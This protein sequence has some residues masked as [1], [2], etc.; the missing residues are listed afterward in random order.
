[1]PHSLPVLD[2]AMLLVSL[3]A[4]ANL[5]IVT[6]FDDRRLKLLLPFG[7][8]FIASFIYFA[9]PGASPLSG[10][11]IVDALI[12]GLVSLMLATIIRP[13]IW[14]LVRNRTDEG[15]GSY[16]KRLDSR[17]WPN[18][19]RQAPPLVLDLARRWFVTI[20]AATG[21]ILGAVAANRFFWDALHKAFSLNRIAI[22]V[23]ATFLSL[24]LLGPIE[25]FVFD[26]ATESPEST[27]AVLRL[28]RG[29]VS[30]RSYGRILLVFLAIF[31]LNVM[32]GCFVEGAS[33]SDAAVV[34]SMVVS[35]VS[36]GAITYYWAAALQVGADSILR[37][38]G[39]ACL[40]LGS[41][42]SLWLALPAVQTQVNASGLQ[43]PALRFV[44]SVA[45]TILVACLIGSL[46]MGIPGSVGGL[47]LDWTRRQSSVSGWLATAILG[48]AIG[49]TLVTDSVL[50]SA[51]AWTVYPTASAVVPTLFFVLCTTIG[52]MIA[53]AFSDFP[54][55]VTAAKGG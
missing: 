12:A 27:A 45:F 29:E 40:V 2:L 37:R 6:L 7:L 19:A 25:T 18:N 17:L 8:G 20:A 44:V 16:R 9:A 3:V 1:M 46:A 11:A 50:A 22:T 36:C 52:W 35:A 4:G 33:A 31:G 23:L 5:A 43:D 32:E 51:F 28:L 49:S 41:M 34:A 47:I 14:I 24:F 38:A 48:V 39:I 30:W 10:V 26:P 15:I 53:L 13:A 54:R 42:L 21:G 55:I